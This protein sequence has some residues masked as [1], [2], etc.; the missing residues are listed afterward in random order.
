[1]STL[2]K[3]TRRSKPPVV[4]FTTVAD[5]LHRLGGIPPERVVMD[6][7]PGTATEADLLRM[8]DTLRLGLFELI[9][10]TLVRKPK[11]TPESYL[12]GEVHYHLRRFLDDHDLGYLYISDALVRV[13]AAQVREPDV[14]FTSW[15]KRP[16]GTI[17]TQPV[18]DIPPDLTVE[19]LSPSNTP[20]EIER[21][22]REY[23]VAGVR[24]VWVIDPATRAAEVYTTLDAR[25]SV[26]PTGALDG[27]DVLPG[28][29]LPLA[30]L[31][32]RFSKPASP[33]RR[34]RGG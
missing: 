14:S 32:K 29:R 21:K 2:A 12:A 3:R 10:R 7:P 5:L 19:V 30:S 16:D 4:K 34:K 28:F 24:L 15:S 33:P 25:V 20:A 1:M 17:P 23:F 26:P 18:T 11:G 22:I 31:F 9:D 8:Q 6:P 27:G 13:T